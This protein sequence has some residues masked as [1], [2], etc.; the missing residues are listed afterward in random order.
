[1]MKKDKS[2][3][4]KFTLSLGGMRTV[5]SFAPMPAIAHDRLRQVQSAKMSKPRQWNW[6][7]WMPRRFRVV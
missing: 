1:M 2:A 5:T 7:I 4:D 3:F 6:R